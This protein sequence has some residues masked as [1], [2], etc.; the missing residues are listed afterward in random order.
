MNKMSNSD[1]MGDI[2]S[3]GGP[4]TTMFTVEGNVSISE[5]PFKFYNVSNKSRTISKVFI[6]VNT[7]PTGA[8]ILI[9]LHK[10]GTTIFTTQSNRPS[11]A[12][13]GFTGES[14]TI[15]VATWPAG[16]YLQLS[17]DQ[18]GSIIAGADL[19]CHVLWS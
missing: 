11:I 13:S 2:S 19:S 4:S 6:S 10:N 3:I 8:T 1:M 18:I 5:S 7:A 14:T 12:I 15:E 9:D 17:V 16:E